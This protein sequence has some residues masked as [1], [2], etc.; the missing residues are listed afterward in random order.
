MSKFIGGIIG[1]GVGIIVLLGTLIVFD[2]LAY[3]DW[4][5]LHALENVIEVL[6]IGR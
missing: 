5:L 6:W 2:Y 3:G 4:K 1:F